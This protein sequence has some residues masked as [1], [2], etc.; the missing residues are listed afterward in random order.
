TREHPLIPSWGLVLTLASFVGFPL[1]LNLLMSPHAPPLLLGGCAVVVILLFLLAFRLP[2][3]FPR[4]LGQAGGSLRWI[5]LAGAALTASNFAVSSILIN[6]LPPVIDI[7]VLVLIYAGALTFVLRRKCSMP[8]GKASI[9]FATG[10]LSIWF[11][12]DF[13]RAFN[14]E[15]E[16]LLVTAGF[17]FVLWRGWKEA[18]LSAPE[19][20]EATGRIS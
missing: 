14:G 19:E 8:I 11:F 16:I 3:E 7:F 18:G 6:W 12:T 2:K 15:P 9:A 4:F 1:G 20:F 17:C 5:F 10:L 13:L